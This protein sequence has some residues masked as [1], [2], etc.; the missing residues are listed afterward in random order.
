MKIICVK[1]FSQVLPHVESNQTIMVCVN[2]LPN[3]VM[4]AFLTLVLL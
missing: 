1:F 2:E 4:F 3:F